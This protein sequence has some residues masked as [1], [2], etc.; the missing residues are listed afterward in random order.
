MAAPAWLTARPIAHRGLHDAAAR[1]IENSPS[2]I[3]AAI[4]AGYAIEVDLQETAD[5]GALVFHDDTLDRLTLETGRVRDRAL[6]DL[7]DVQMRDGG[8]PLWDLDALLARVGGQ[9]P[10]I[11]ELKSRNARDGQRAFVTAVAARLAAYDGPAAL[12]SFDPEMLAI[13]RACAPGLPRGIIAEDTRHAPY[14]KR[15]FGVMERFILRHM[16][17]W[18]RTRPD[19][20]SYSV[21]SLPAPAPWLMRRCGI[22]VITWTVRSAQD[23][24]I[25]RRYAD[26]IV[27]EGFDPAAT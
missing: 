9:V 4:D 17:H 22:P 18:P 25:A 10:L 26:Q 7:L 5:H 1:R 16:L 19:F 15:R 14:W 20:V 12:K 21:R 11:I 3:Q 13:L 24:E 27:F 8:D 6:A 2:A 23:R